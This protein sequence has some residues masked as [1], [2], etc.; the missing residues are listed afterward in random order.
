MYMIIFLCGQHSSDL[1]GNLLYA[2]HRIQYDMLA[3]ALLEL[4]CLRCRKHLSLPC[5][6]QTLIVLAFCK[7]DVRA[8]QHFAMPRH[9]Y[10]PG[11]MKVLFS[12]FL[13]ICD[14]NDDDNEDD[15][16]EED[17]KNDRVE[18]PTFWWA[19]LCGG[20][21]NVVLGSPHPISHGRKLEEGE[22]LGRGIRVG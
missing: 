3:S 21:G 22:G 4:L 5:F 7:W 2:I 18:V 6:G 9:W 20:R 19:P 10:N 13:L 14:E 8:F 1:V 16:G 12:S 15:V 11:I 17:G